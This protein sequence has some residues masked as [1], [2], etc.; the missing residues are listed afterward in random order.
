MMRVSVS[1]WLGPETI[2]HVLESIEAWDGFKA[3]MDVLLKPNAVMGG[4]PK[5]PCRGITTSPVMVAAVI[6]LV[7]EKGAKS[8]IIAEGSIELPSL[9]LDTA[10]AYAW[11]G[12]K[13][14]AKRK[15]VELVDLNKGP[16][17]DFTLSDN[18]KIEIAEAV[19]QAD[20]V[21]NLPVLKTH[22]QTL[23]TICLKNLKG[24][25]S[26][27]TKKRCHTETD[28]NRAIAE[29]NQHIPCHLNVVD[30]LTATEMGPTPTGKENQV[31]DMGLILAGKDRLSCDVVGSYLLGYDATQIPY[32]AHYAQLEGRSAQ[33]ENVEIVGEDPAAFRMA[34]EYTSAWA[35]DMM[36]KYDIS[37]IRFPPYGDQVC[38]GCGFNLWAGLIQ[39]CRETKGSRFN[40]VQLCVGGSIEPSSAADT[41]ILVGKCA[42]EKYREK[43]GVIKI[44]GCPP[45]PAKLAKKLIKELC[46]TG[47]P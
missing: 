13:A 35:D 37:G 5:I 17:R 8:V 14:L 4:S 18:T 25:L 46:E 32:I 43:K 16:H 1:R 15:Q 21:I 10:A 22:N 9:K 45:D 40:N 29:F 28:L 42:I 26:M 47:E 2:K 24:C 27:D 3:G 11:S 33:Y 36:E 19:Y 6:D 23:T 44:A 20:F 38:S 30:A 7:R 34:L 41:N 39:F 12:L 31:R